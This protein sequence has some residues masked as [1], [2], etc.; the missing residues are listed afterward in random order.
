MAKKQVEGIIYCYTNKVNNKKYIGQTTDENSRKIKFRTQEEYCTS[1]KNGGRL[2]HFDN[3]RKKYGIDSFV[4]EVLERII[5][6]DFESL[7][8]K[9]D[10]LERFYIS[11]YDSYNNG[12]NSTTGGS[13][14][15]IASEETRHLMSNIAKDRFQDPSHHPMYGKHHSEETKKKISTSKKGTKTGGSNPFSKAVLCYTKQGEFVR[16]FSSI[17]EANIFVGKPT[18]MTGINKCCAGTTLSAYGYVWKYKTN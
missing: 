6:E 12:Y 9:L 14:G 3:A 18:N 1:H 4:Y 15:W 8:L 13:S 2:S 16:E 5:S 11:K 17:A 7:H 10:E